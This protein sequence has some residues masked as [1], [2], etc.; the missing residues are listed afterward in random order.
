MSEKQLVS[1][2]QQTAR[3]MNAYLEV[4]GQRDA[5]GSGSTIGLPDAFLYCAGKCLPVEFKAQKGRLS[6]GQTL[7]QHRR[8]DQHVHTF[9]VRTV[10]EFVDLING[11]RRFA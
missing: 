2:C 3:A 8:A 4:A 5:R 1:D 10:A 6:P 11:A 7:A 9:I